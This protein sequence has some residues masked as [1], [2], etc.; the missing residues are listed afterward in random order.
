MARTPKQT[1]TPSGPPE[2]VGA[3][4]PGEPRGVKSA[5]A[6]KSR[7]KAK[8]AAPRKKAPTSKTGEV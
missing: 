4:K 2:T 5:T 6:P 3:P 1:R 8:P 7:P